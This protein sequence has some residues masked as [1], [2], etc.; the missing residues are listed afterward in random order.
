MAIVY[1]D[2]SMSLDGFIAGPNV[3]VENP[4]GDRGE[5]LHEWM[6]AGKTDEESAE[7]EEQLFRPCGA[8]VIGRRMLDVGIDP[9]G[10][11]PT[12][13]MPVYVLTHRPH[14]PVVKRGGTTY[15]FL[16]GGLLSVLEQARAAA[17]GKDVVIGGGAN[18]VQQCL[19]AGV[20]EE[21]RLHL[22]PVLLGAGTRLFRDVGRLKVATRSS[23]TGPGG[24]M[25]L[26]FKVSQ[27][28]GAVSD[29]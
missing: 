15:Y 4:L 25:H 19:A 21:I 16:T 26:T 9:W 13:H 7:F 24:V 18:I 28:T 17:D 1:F 14:E 6:F 20:V 5:L 10:D 3:G 2:V 23:D 29:R 12:F 8:M 11:D 22:V 27:P